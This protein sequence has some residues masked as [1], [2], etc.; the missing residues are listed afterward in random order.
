MNSF[1]KTYINRQYDV[2]VVYALNYFIKFA[3]FVEISP[4]SHFIR[5]RSE[6]S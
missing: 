5:I 4:S 2:H 6:R 1:N 3:F